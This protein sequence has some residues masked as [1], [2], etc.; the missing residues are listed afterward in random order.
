MKN[1]TLYQNA[2]NALQY[3]TLTRLDLFYSVNKLNQSIQNPTM[4][5]WQT[6]KRIFQYLK[7]SVKGGIHLK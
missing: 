3:L 5:D 7:G 2:I 6:I 4:V 1:P